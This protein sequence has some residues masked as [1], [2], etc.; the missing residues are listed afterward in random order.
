VTLL[1]S[2]VFSP[3]GKRLIASEYDAVKAWDM[4]TG[5]EVFALKEAPT[6]AAAVACAPDGQR[7]ATGVGDGLVVLWDAVT[8][9]QLRTLKGLGPGK[10]SLAFSPDGTRVAAGTVN[11]QLVKV[12]DAAAGEELHTFKNVNPQYVAFSLDGKR[13]AV[14]CSD[15]TVRLWDAVSGTEIVVLK[16][17]PTSV[18]S[19]AFNVDGATLVSADL[20]GKVILWD[21]KSLKKLREWQLPGKVNRVLFAPDGRH[22]LTANG[23]GT[24]Y[25]VRLAAPSEKVA[26]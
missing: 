2:L 1:Y 19:V 18:W 11:Q 26:R 14:A 6:R 25:I 3:D 23:N 16:E 5:D 12:W 7:L 8:G 15:W 21:N 17:H 4:A 22:L 24:S 13:L 20:S 9:K 10:T